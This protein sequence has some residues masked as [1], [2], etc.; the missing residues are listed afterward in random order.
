MIFHLRLI[1]V[2]PAYVPSACSQWCWRQMGFVLIIQI[3]IC[4]VS[5]AGGHV[6]LY[7]HFDLVYTAL[8]LFDYVFITICAPYVVSPSRILLAHAVYI[9]GPF[10]EHGVALIPAGISYY[11]HHKAGTEIIHPFERFNRL[12]VWESISNIISRFMIFVITNLLR[13]LWPKQR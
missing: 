11:T 8:T 6:M 5:T 3:S 12:T 1:P 13:C 2:W 4:N 9:W 7:L 10:Y